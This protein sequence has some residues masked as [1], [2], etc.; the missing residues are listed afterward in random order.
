MA[1]G[2]EDLQIDEFAAF[3]LHDFKVEDEVF[4]VGEEGCVK[5]LLAVLVAMCFHAFAN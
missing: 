2:G 3:V 1:C 5:K 4:V